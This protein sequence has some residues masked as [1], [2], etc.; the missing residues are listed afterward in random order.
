MK[1]SYFSNPLLSREKH[2]LVQI[3]NS[4]PK[5]FIPD[6][7]WNEAIPDWKTT[8]AP[9]KD[10]VISEEEYRIRYRRQLDLRKDALSR[11]LALIQRNARE[12]EVVLI[13]Y[14]TPGSFCHRHILAQ[15]LK[16]NGFAGDIK[17]MPNSLTASLF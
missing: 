17:E 13:C 12:K 11:S 10:Q 5:G 7:R 14:E 6:A 15:W 16:N 4:V 2:Y 8:V 3:S 1:T 9:Y